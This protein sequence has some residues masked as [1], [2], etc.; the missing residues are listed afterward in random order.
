MIQNKEKFFK[1]ICNKLRLKCLEII[2]RTKASHIG[3]IY[4][5]LDIIVYIYLYIIKF[6]KKK[7]NHD[8]IMSKGH[9]GLAVYLALLTFVVFSRQKTFFQH[10]LYSKS[11]L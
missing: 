1:K 6:N 8:F 7:P 9:A 5:C 2:F 4:S 10:E 11:G 3:S